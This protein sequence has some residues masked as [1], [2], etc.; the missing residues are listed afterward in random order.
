LGILAKKPVFKIKNMISFIFYTHSTRVENLNQSIF[1]LLRNE[2]K[3]DK[4]IIVIYQDKGPLINNVKT[5]NMNLSTYHKPKMCNYGVENSKYEINCILDSDRILPK[6]YFFNVLNNIKKNQMITTSF[7]LNLLH[8]CSNED[9]INE[10]YKYEI[11]HRSQNN[12][13]RRKNLFSGNTIFFKED[14]IKIGKMDEQYE[15]YGYADSD[16]NQTA[17]VNNIES[18]YLNIPEIHLFHNKGVFYKEQLLEDFQ[19]LSAINVIKYCV[20]WKI[21]S[22]IMHCVCKEVLNKLNSYSNEELK[23]EFIKLYKKIV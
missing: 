23:K 10:N 13:L 2:E 19:I 9:I 4:E 17:I 18:V 15:G 12:E 20:K 6:N 1:F 22:N 14:Y 16:M 21:K 8:N 7:M 11:E 5:F 3:I